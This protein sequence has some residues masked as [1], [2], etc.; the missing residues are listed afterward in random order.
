MA[1]IG[2]LLESS[3][4]I[5][6]N[7][8]LRLRRELETHGIGSEIVYT[9]EMANIL[10]G[11]IKEGTAYLGNLDVTLK[12][13]TSPLGLWPGGTL[14]AYGLANH[15]SHPSEKYLGD[16]QTASN[17]EATESTFRFFEFWYE[18][19]FWDNRAAVLLGQHD[20][21]SDFFVSEHASLYLNS[22]FGIQP[23]ASGNVPTSIFPVAGLAARL[24]L[25]LW[26]HLT[27]MSAIYDGDPEDQA[28]N[29]HGWRWHLGS[30]EGFFLVHE[31]ALDSGFFPHAQLP[32]GTYKFGAWQHTAR[33]DD[34]LATN[35]AGDALVNH[36]NYGFYG[37]IDQWIFEESAN[38][39]RGLAAFLQ[40]GAV[41]KNRNTV[42]FYIGLGI[43]YTGLIP[44]REQDIT[45]VAFNHASLSDDVRTGDNNR[46][47]GE[48]VLEITHRAVLTPWFAV[49]HDI[50]FIF[51][52]GAD[53][54]LVDSA[55]FLLRAEISF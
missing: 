29:R 30:E 37:L 51:D 31:I 38:K 24:R 23:D 50:Q 14:F 17:I 19:T 16:L 10:R 43:N 27:V 41:P 36:H 42:D 39:G 34:V 4:K 53:K 7:G 3:R 54:S 22:S 12:M 28:K 35:E 18:Q 44:G 15:G 20:L 48:S 13:A 33:F 49:Q 55:I 40:V 45:G 47:Q 9:A 26:Q 5:S 46:D 8:W 11:G 21:N 25:E 6:Q 52:T 2:S 1:R 32:T